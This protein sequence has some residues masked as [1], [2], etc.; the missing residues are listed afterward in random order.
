MNKQFY[1]FMLGIFYMNVGFSQTNQGARLT[2]MGNNG[3]A[4]KDLWGVA[5]NPA[6]ITNIQ[7]PSIQLNHQEH[8]FAKSVDNQA[9]AFVVPVN[10]QSFGLNLQRYGIPEYH[11]IQAGIIFTRQFGSKLAIGLRAN[12]HQ[13]KINNYGATTGISL[14]IG[15]IY[16]LSNELCFGFYINN[17]SHENYNTKAIY[18][19]IPTTAYIGIA[20]RTSDKLLIATTM[21]REDVSTG[22]D[23][24]V[25][26][27]FSLRAGIS[28]NPFTHYFGIGLNT[29]KIVTDFTFTKHP[30]FGYSPQLTIGYVF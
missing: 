16:E 23:Y 22:I 2:A 15:T 9:L 21:S 14:D 29:S 28:L 26:K 24:Q 5:T 25:I 11:Y 6:S 17:P 18:I 20:Y 19:T 13:L 30:N 8:I 4:V 27:A 12:Y 1:L 3:A 7:F 10:R